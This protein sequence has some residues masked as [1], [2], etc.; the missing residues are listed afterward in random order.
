MT[1]A[2]VILTGTEDIAAEDVRRKFPADAR[3]IIQ[4][5]YNS[6]RPRKKTSK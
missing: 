3:K 1:A 4:E 6:L 2:K 5:S